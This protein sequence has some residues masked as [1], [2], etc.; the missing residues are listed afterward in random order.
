[1]Q[2]S[3]G[4]HA[5]K[6]AAYQMCSKLEAA[7]GQ[8]FNFARKR[9]EHIGGMIMLPDGA[10]EW[11]ADAGELWRQTEASERRADAQTAR[12]IEFSIPRA[13]PA[14]QRLEFARAVVQP[15]V[16][17]GMAAQLD[18]HCTRASDGEEQPHAHVLLT[19]RR[20]DGD[21]F[22]KRKERDWNQQFTADKGRTERH[23]IAQRMNNWMSAHGITGCVDAA[24]S[25]VEN[26]EP[27]VPRW[28]FERAR[29]TG[30]IGDQLNELLAHRAARK[31]GL[32]TQQYLAAA[33]QAARQAGTEIVKL[34]NAKRQLTAS[35]SPADAVEK[36]VRKRRFLA[37]LLREH[38]DTKWLPP[39]VANRLKGV[40]LDKEKRTATLFL[41]DG[42]RI[43]D[44]GDRISLH[45]RWT[46]AAI[47]EMAE[48][49]ARHGWQSVEVTGSKDF[50]DA[51]AVELALRVPPVEV[52]NHTL[53]RA[54]QQR[55]D[56]ELKRRADAEAQQREQAEIKRQ[57]A[58]AQQQA[59]QAARAA[60]R[61]PQAADPEAAGYTPAPAYRP[62]FGGP[63]R[64]RN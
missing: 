49:A 14:D 22:S 39:E 6:V 40:K 26:S 48:A 11:A 43:V 57:L 29:K 21:G 3:A 32:S 23:A 5:V 35:L 31:H 20:F 18:L 60:Q 58:A 16:D 25:A 62:R 19:M 17:L 54:A 38:Y 53:S 56:A 7:D 47:K 30:E 10:P 34:E 8:R 51:I 44:S 50:R 61:R 12:L 46:Q 63:Q 52:S 27:N 59:V 28:Q 45:G 36:E 37:R 13:V 9:S 55:V 15:Y 64:R 2:R 1:V 4:N 41:K 33:K 24:R 42:G